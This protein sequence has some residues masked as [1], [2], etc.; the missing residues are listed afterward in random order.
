M[1]AIGYFGASFF[2]V[3]GIYCLFTIRKTK[4]LDMEAKK[5][6]NKKRIL[7]SLII[8]ILLGILLLSISNYANR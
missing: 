2:F 1:E 5:K 8:S 6:Y 7:I 4:E 3:W